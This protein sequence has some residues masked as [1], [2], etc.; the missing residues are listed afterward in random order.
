M[1]N[2]QA[3]QTPWKVSYTVTNTQFVLDTTQHQP[4]VEIE[5]SNLALA[6]ITIRDQAGTMI[7]TLPVSTSNTYKLQGGFY[8]LVATRAIGTDFGAI[9]HNHDDR[10][11]T[12]GQVDT[13]LTGKSD[14]GHTHDDRYYTESEIDT[15]MA[16]KADLVAGKV[17]S[18]QLPSYVDDVAE[19]ANLA[20]F[21]VTGETGK[22]YLAL[23]TEFTYRWSGSAYVKISDTAKEDTANKTTSISGNETSN[24]KFPTV[25]AIYDWV[26]GIDSNVVHKTGNENIDGIKTFIGTEI[27]IKKPLANQRRIVFSNSTD[28]RQM[29]VYQPENLNDLRIYNTGLSK[30]QVS[31]KEGGVTEFNDLIQI[32]NGSADPNDGKIGNNTY[33]A[34]LNIVGINGDTTYRKVRLWGEI[35]QTENNGTNTFAGYSDFGNSIRTQAE[36]TSIIADFT[37][38]SRMGLVKRS[39]YNPYIGVDQNTPLDIIRH[40]VSNNIRG[41]EGTGT[42]QQLMRLD[43]SNSNI[44]LYNTNYQDGRKSM[45]YGGGG[46]SGVASYINNYAYSRTDGTRYQTSMYIDRDSA[47]V[48]ID[49]FQIWGYPQDSSGNNLDFANMFVLNYDRSNGRVDFDLPRDRQWISYTPSILTDTGSVNSY[50]RRV[51]QYKLIGTTVFVRFDIVVN[52]WGSASGGVTITLPFT[53]HTNWR[54]DTPVTGFCGEPSTN[55]ITAGKGFPVIDG[56]GNISMLNSIDASRLTRA[57]CTNSTVFRGTPVYEVAR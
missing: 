33:A 1:L 25:K 15:Q 54:N 32:K 40:N 49:S 28:S 12:K 37:G 19:Y 41:N 43:Q 13:F 14:V 55:P 39:G 23:D 50:S 2:K 24:I 3:I 44:S 57:G 16:N 48:G 6:P 20:G 47:V 56:G 26:V 4:E 53:A 5:I 38:W 45:M 42:V 30:D 18:S 17:P 22:I 36:N 34:G 21:P 27:Q 46:L 7:D 35:T 29:I 51:G 9:L 31:F 11:Y 8:V 52:D 10:Y